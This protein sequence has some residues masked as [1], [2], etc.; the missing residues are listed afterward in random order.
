MSKFFVVVFIFSVLNISIYAGCMGDESAEAAPTV[1]VDPQF[2]IS[3]STSFCKEMSKDEEGRD[4][5]VSQWQ[6]GE[7]FVLRLSDLQNPVV[8][9][10]SGNGEAILRIEKIGNGSRVTASVQYTSSEKVKTPPLKLNVEIPLKSDSLAIQGTCESA[11]DLGTF[12]TKL[13]AR[14]QK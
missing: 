11:A 10:I 8:K 12:E 4:Q 14:K 5:L 2:K 6:L 13:S 1:P 7:S 9:T 3:F